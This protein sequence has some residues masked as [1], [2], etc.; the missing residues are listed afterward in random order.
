MTSLTPSQRLN[1]IYSEIISK[2]YLMPL[3]GADFDLAGLV[4]EAVGRY[5]D[6][7]EGWVL[8]GVQP[9]G[10]KKLEPNEVVKFDTGS[11][12]DQRPAPKPR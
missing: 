3:Q 2:V 4:I 6:E 8:T 11:E 1:E 9:E 5:L 12:A 7:Q 10:A